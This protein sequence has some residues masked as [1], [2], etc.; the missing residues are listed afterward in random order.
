MSTEQRVADLFRQKGYRAKS[1]TVTFDD[2][3]PGTA[4]EIRVQVVGPAT[5]EAFPDTSYYSSKTIKVTL[6]GGLLYR[7]ASLALFVDLL[8][9]PRDDFPS[10]KDLLRCIDWE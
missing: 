4:T 1:V 2:K 5:S 3:D 8:S 6:K 9:G 10:R 7:L